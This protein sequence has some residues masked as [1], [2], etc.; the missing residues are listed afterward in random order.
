[1]KIISAT[2]GKFADTP[3]CKSL[4]N[5]SNETLTCAIAEDN[6]TGL[7]RIYNK[8][9][10]AETLCFV[11][12]DVA[13]LNFWWMDV[14]EEGL[15]HFDIVGVM[16]DRRVFPDPRLEY[17]VRK[18]L[19]TDYLSNL[20]G[21]VSA[22]SDWCNSMKLYFGPLGE[23]KTLD[24]ML[25]AANGKRLLETGVTFDEDFDFHF[26]DMAFCARARAAGLT[27]GTIPLS[28]AH[29]S[30]GALD[31]PWIQALDLYRS[32]YGDS[33]IDQ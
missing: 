16:G 17:L 30:K 23:V 20:S 25:I 5:V 13:I 14:I 7:S 12:D 18:H 15:K 32:K 1:M 27:M 9:I 24:G 2:R 19:V 26:Y 21:A 31:D 33:L 29:K 4:T 3:L 28:T 11:H 22:G 6:M 10:S 8:E